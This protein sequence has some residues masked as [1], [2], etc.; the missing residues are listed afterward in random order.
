LTIIGAHSAG[1]GEQIERPELVHTDDDVG[2]SGLG[3]RLAIGEFVEV[4]HP[5]LLGL[6]VGIRGPLPGLDHL[7]GDTLLAEEHAETLVADVVD[8]PLG[9]EELGQLGQ[10]PGGK[11]QVVVDRSGQGDLFDLA[12]FGQG[13]LRRSTPRVLRS[14]GVEAVV[15]EVVDDLP[16]P[17][18]GGEGDLGDGRD[19]HPLGGP[20]DDLGSS[21]TH[22]RARTPAHDGQELVPLFVG[23]LSYCHAF[24]H[25]TTLRDLEV[26]VV[27]ATHQRCRSRALETQ[28]TTNPRW[29]D[30]QRPYSAEDVIRLRCSFHNEHSVARRGAERLWE[31]VHTED[32]VNVLGA[33]SGSQAVQMVNAG[34]KAIYLS[35][36]QV[37]A[38]ANL[39]EQV[40]PDQSLYAANS[41]PAVVRRLKN[42]LQRADQ[43]EWAEGSF[44]HQLR[45]WMVPIVADAE[46]VSGVP[47]TSSSS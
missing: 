24:C 34:L 20:Q 3:Y 33:L 8:H 31:L 5:V 19:V 38:D 40:Y 46:E 27:D 23:D 45:E 1:S 39:S 37:A 10:A 47:S 22:H 11:G 16:D 29:S 43:I 41:V 32:Y 30:V 7:K 12:P 4:Q 42:A 18:L 14:Q 21:P 28:W 35:G 26:K 17:I 44:R 9:D 15:V 2:V 6:E 25:G 36:W 13:E